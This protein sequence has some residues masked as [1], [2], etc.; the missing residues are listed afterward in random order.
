MYK[1][2]ASNCTWQ[3]SWDE[4][5][6]VVSWL[7]KV[8]DSPRFSYF[9]KVSSNVEPRTPGPE[10]LSPACWIS[11][12]SLSHKDRFNFVV[13]FEVPVIHKFSFVFAFPPTSSS[14]LFFCHFFK[15]K[16]SSS[17]CP[18]IMVTLCCLWWAFPYLYS[19]HILISRNYTSVWKFYF[20]RMYEQQLSSSTSLIG[21]QVL[22]LG[23]KYYNYFYF[24]L[25]FI[26]KYPGH[27]MLFN[28][29]C[30]WGFLFFF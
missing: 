22:T 23:S 21:C 14:N 26:T 9:F 4:A 3:S 17:F 10:N 29:K 6:F 1:E 8:T 30:N 11:Q 20:H 16:K 2:T 15:G 5:H 28:L 12:C 19:Y 27:W 24:D 18:L 7:Q 25:E 13:A